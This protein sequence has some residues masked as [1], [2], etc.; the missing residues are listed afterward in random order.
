MKGLIH[1]ATIVAVLFSVCHRSAATMDMNLANTQWRLVAFGVPDAQAP[2]IEG[3]S[4]TLQLGGDGRITGSGGCNT[5]GGNYQA[6]GNTITFSEIIS[7]MRACADEAVTRQ[8]KRYF[9]ALGSAASYELVA[10]HLRIAYAEGH[11]VLEFVK[12]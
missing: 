11:G 4:I 3:S 2:A 10:D 8:E 7:T 12:S 9:E 5:Y 1:T 6:Q